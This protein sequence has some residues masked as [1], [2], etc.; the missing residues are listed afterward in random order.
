MRLV[1]QVVQSLVHLYQV[2]SSDARVWAA[3]IGLILPTAAAGTLVPAV[4]A[5]RIEPTRRC[6]PNSGAP[7]MACMRAGTA[8][9]RRPLADRLTRRPHGSAAANRRRRRISR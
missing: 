7:A 4:R 2:T 3:A 9:E 6:D 5:S 8:G 1:R